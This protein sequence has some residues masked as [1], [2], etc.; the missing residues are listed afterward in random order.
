LVRTG[1]WVPARARRAEHRD[2]T[3]FRV[4][5]AIRNVVVE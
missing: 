2:F 3:R 1:P 4:W 5:Q